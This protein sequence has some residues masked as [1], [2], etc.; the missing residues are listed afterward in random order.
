MQ[1]TDKM[2]KWNK[3]IWL[4]GGLALILPICIV[5]LLLILFLLPSNNRDNADSARRD[6]M[7]SL[8]LRW[9]RLARFPES[10]RDLSV[11]T[12]GNIFT[13]SFRVH[14]NA[15]EEVITKWIADSPG[16][17]EA[18]IQSTVDGKEKYVI[19]PGDG[20]NYAEVI[21]DFRTGQVDIYV[22]WS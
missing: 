16:L 13:R 2:K 20:A 21:V 9:G 4:A 18:V 6:E 14:F 10:V 17:K 5:G 7:I 19:S 22:A 8:T 11:R 12:E 15:S 1:M 3:L